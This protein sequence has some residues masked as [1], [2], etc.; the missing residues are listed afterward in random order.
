M[1]GFKDEIAKISRKNY[2]RHYFVGHPHVLSTVM[3]ILMN[4]RKLKNK[5]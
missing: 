2:D 1:I 5:F 3:R 4:K